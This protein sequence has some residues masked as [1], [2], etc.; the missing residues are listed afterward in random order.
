M[1]GEEICIPSFSFA[2]AGNLLLRLMASDKECTC[3]A[4]SSSDK[5]GPRKGSQLGDVSYQ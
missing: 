4:L 3:Q 1:L 2:P 5:A